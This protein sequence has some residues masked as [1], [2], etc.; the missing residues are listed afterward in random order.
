MLTKDDR[1]AKICWQAFLFSQI[2][3]LILMFI[4]WK[5]LRNRRS[6]SKTPLVQLPITGFANISKHPC[7]PLY[8]ANLSLSFSLSYFHINFNLQ[9]IWSGMPSKRDSG[10]AADPHPGHLL[11][12]LG[13]AHH[14]RPHRRTRGHRLCTP[15]PHRA[16]P[17]RCPIPPRLKY[18]KN[19]GYSS[20]A[21]HLTAVE[22]K[23]NGV[24]DV[25]ALVPDG[26]LLSYSSSTSSS[27]STSFLTPPPFLL[28]LLS[29][30]S[31]ISRRHLPLFLHFLNTFTLL[32]CLLEPC[33]WLTRQINDIAYTC[34]KL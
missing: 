33:H 26:I 18:L 19:Q 1:M 3:A 27:S 16:C 5:R 17:P 4:G 15:R 22:G 34:G 23:A 20:A 28:L 31:Y 2:F 10:P 13:G 25:S 29:Y 12:L 14:A 11:R 24:L 30:I 6:T 21:R 32:D 8:F 7:T 9:H